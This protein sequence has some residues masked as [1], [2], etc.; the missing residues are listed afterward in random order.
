[1]HHAAV[2]T[3]PYTKLVNSKTFQ[4]EF[5]KASITVLDAC[6]PG[7]TFVDQLNRAIDIGSGFGLLNHIAA[8]HNWSPLIRK[9]FI[10]CFATA[11]HRISGSGIFACFALAK[12]AID[13]I[14]F[15]IHELSK[16][17]TYAT[18]ENIE[19][20]MKNSLDE[21]SADL[22]LDIVNLTG[23]SGRINILIGSKS[24][25]ALEIFSSH[26]FNFGIDPSFC[27]QDIKRDHGFIF[28]VDGAIENVSEIDNMLQ[29]CHA[30]KST[31]FIV[32]RKF[33]NE[34]ISTLNANFQQKMLDVIPVKIN[35]D[36][37]H[38]NVFSDLA[39]TTLSNVVNKESGQTTSG[40]DPHEMQL[41]SRVQV[42]KKI[43]ELD[44]KATKEHVYGVM[45]EEDIRTILMSRIDSLNT[46]VS[47][48]WLPADATKS[49]L[50]AHIDNRFKFGFSL[51][52]SLCTTGLIKID[53]RELKH[54]FKNLKLPFIPAGILLNS[55]HVASNILSS[56]KNVGGCIVIE[57]V[58][59]HSN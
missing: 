15:D 14:A 46:N 33:G 26:T 12:L 3:E 50:Y 1:M 56:V 31:L 23:T 43:K 10:Q 4:S 16:K 51:L 53:G 59:K 57:P 37:S 30:N 45:N 41:N 13:N 44:E 49:G 21:L 22:I 17:S 47:T 55:L 24:K 34:V 36:I 11:E 25:C 2:P 35:D 42:R 58:N 9:T 7:G 54:I 40:F 6:I 19:Q 29:Y 20:L 28:L 48:L 5:A 18:S 8:K 32:A 39:V 38:L 52:D 27:T